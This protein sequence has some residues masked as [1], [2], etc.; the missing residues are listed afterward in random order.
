MIALY[1]RAGVIAGFTK[2][3]MLKI[4]TRKSAL[5]FAWLMGIFVFLVII[6]APFLVVLLQGH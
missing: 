6:L 2:W 1:M 4:K 3:A 5:G